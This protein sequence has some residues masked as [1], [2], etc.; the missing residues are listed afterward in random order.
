MAVILDMIGHAYDALGIKAH[1][2]RLSLRGDT[3]KYVGDAEMWDRGEQ[4][5][6]EVLDRRGLRYESAAGEGAFYG[7]AAADREARRQR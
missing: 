6:A 2:Y 5:L 7:D 1:H 4:A 3:S